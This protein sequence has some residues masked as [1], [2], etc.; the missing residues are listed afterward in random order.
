MAAL[1]TQRS[2]LRLPR[3]CCSLYFLPD[4]PGILSFLTVFY[5]ANE[6]NYRHQFSA[7]SHA[8]VS[9]G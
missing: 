3:R 5:Y 4:N 6:K 9:Y 8:C 7:I 1:L 2:L